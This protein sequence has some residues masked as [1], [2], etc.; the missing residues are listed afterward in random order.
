MHIFKTYWVLIYSLLGLNA[1]GQTI[2]RGQVVG[3][4]GFLPGATVTLH[5]LPDSAFVLGTA[6]DEH[7]E[8][9]AEVSI[10]P[11]LMHVAAVGYKESYRLITQED[12]GYSIIRMQ[13]DSLHQILRTV[14]ISASKPVLEHMPDRTVF[15]VSSSTSAMGSD[16]YELLRKTPGVQVNNGSINIVGKGNVSIMMN[17]KLVRISGEELEAMLRS[18]ASD[19]ISKI[20]V[21]TT[22]PA[23]YDAEG[24][25][26]IINIVT[27]K[28]TRQGWN[29]SLSN[30]YAQGIRLGGMISGGANYRSPKWFVF[31]TAFARR[32][33]FTMLVDNTTYYTQQKQEQHLVQINR[34]G[35]N[36]MELG[37]D[38]NISPS[39]NIGMFATYRHRTRDVKQD[40]HT[41]VMQIPALE[42]DSIMHTIAGEPF[43][44]SYLTAGID[45]DWKIDTAGTRLR[46]SANYFYDTNK[47][48]RIFYT[49]HTSP[50]GVPTGHT[51]YKHTAGDQSLSIKAIMA[52]VDLPL[53]WVNLSVGAKT[54]FISNNNGY[55]INGLK[56]GTFTY[57]E[58]TQAAYWSG[59]REWA[60]WHA[61]LGMRAEYTQTTVMSS[62]S[63]GIFKNSY[64]KIF[65]TGYLQYEVTKYLALHVNYSRR[66]E[67][68]DFESLNPFR[69]YSTDVSY[70]A[71]NPFLQPYT[72]DNV[73]IGGTIKSV[74]SFRMYVTHKKN[75]FANVS[76]IDEASKSFYFTTAN[77]GDSWNY[78]LLLST[79]VQ[80]SKYWQIMTQL[81]GF[82]TN[83]R[84]G[85]YNQTNSI[86]TPSF[87]AEVN[88]IITLNKSRT[89]TAEMG[90]RYQSAQQ[91][92]IDFQYPY[93]VVWGGVKAVM[94]DNRLI[95]SFNFS[96]PF[97]TDYRRLE[98]P[99][100]RTYSRSY[101]DRRSFQIA[102]SW[103][104]GNRNIKKT[105]KSDKILTET[106]RAG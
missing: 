12:T 4:D 58:L 33:I 103:K 95:A 31:G 102:L 49:K 28:A 93:S 19:N 21:I 51:A 47:I 101:Y 90:A 104:F 77:T 56:A 42:K 36:S 27:K 29:G 59:D 17:E 10:K 98:N 9:Y 72:S 6:A 43:S 45:Y 34:A 63:T 86:S 71:G 18:M 37:A 65:P 70:F 20:E 84:S 26:G 66:I 13:P 68:P 76:V 35:Y 79:T 75:F 46:L 52:D 61:K 48:E 73:E 78:G 39:A 30:T 85:H 16:A 40:Y 105:D 11:L 14:T 44:R 23:K 100:N 97:N 96:D 64:C 22:P 15:N 80:A 1:Y 67:R 41:D 99:Y 24:N 62:A 53:K 25:S 92:D 83:M 57:S 2:I 60:K 32:N 50:E 91:K 54:S 3:A 81:N 106:N 87:S 94:F 5:T 74:Y 82:F 69:D 38:Y 88:N 55:F 89:L 7:G 8:F